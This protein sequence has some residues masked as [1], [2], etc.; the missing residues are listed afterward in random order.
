M[1]LNTRTTA[2]S[3]GSRNVISKPPTTPDLN[4]RVRPDGYGTA[5]NSASARPISSMVPVTGP[6][7]PPRR[8]IFARPPSGGAAVGT[9][10]QLL[11]AANKKKEIQSSRL[12]GRRRPFVNRA[13]DRAQPASQARAALAGMRGAAQ[14][15]VRPSASPESVRRSLQVMS[16]RAGRGGNTRATPFAGNGPNNRIRG[17]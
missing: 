10:A 14:R 1:A 3:A 2:A 9:A 16:Q 4:T 6:A 17:G 15:N 5:A 13:Q 12:V 11:A 8:N 7:V